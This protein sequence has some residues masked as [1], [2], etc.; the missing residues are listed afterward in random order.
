MTGRLATPGRK[1]HRGRRVKDQPNLQTHTSDDAHLAVDRM[2]RSEWSRT[3]S[4]ADALGPKEGAQPCRVEGVTLVRHSYDLVKFPVLYGPSLVFVVQ[5]TKTATFGSKN[6]VYD[7]ER[8]LVLTSVVPFV[9]S[10]FTD[11]GKPVL[12][13]FVHLRGDLVLELL[14]AMD[15]D[16]SQTWG[17]QLAM[18]EAQS[19][20]GE[21]EF[22]LLR[23]LEAATD[24]RDGK[25]LGPAIIREMVYRV[26]CGPGGP[27]IRASLGLDGHFAQI[28]KAIRNM[29][30]NLTRPVSVPDLAGSVGMSPSVFHL[31]F[32][33]VTHSSPLQ[34]IKALR[35]HQG[36]A[37]MLAEGVTVAEA[38]ERVG[39]ESS[40]QFSREYKRLFG[41]APAIEMAKLRASLDSDL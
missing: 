22:A 5:G 21:I 7:H 41:E 39:Y 13:V 9:W 34:Y 32:K 8:Y 14:G 37:L 31:Y 2:T 26:L 6:Y 36:R 11:K 38:S 1:P 28:A 19:L 33:Q 27:S 20:T 10:A 16:L 23:L 18:F 29:R 35:L 40:S 12:S 4:L 17:E 25:V 15:F 30:E 3:A 24:E